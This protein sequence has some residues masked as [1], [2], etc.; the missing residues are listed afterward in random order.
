V[1]GGAPHEIVHQGAG[2]AC[3]WADRQPGEED[4]MRDPHEVEPWGDPVTEWARVTITRETAK[5]PVDTLVCEPEVLGGQPH[6]TV[7][8]WVGQKQVDPSQWMSPD[9]PEVSGPVVEVTAGRI[10]RRV[11]PI[12]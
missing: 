5:G 10:V 11:A 9:N 3:Q 1:H 8:V 4:R 6:G 7:R 2:V 12:T